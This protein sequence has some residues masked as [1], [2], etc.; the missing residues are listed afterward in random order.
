MIEGD[1][2]EN[3]TSLE[4][5]AVA[6]D[7]FL[8]YYDDDA[9]VRVD[10]SGK[11]WMDGTITDALSCP[12]TAS[13]EILKIKNGS[14]EVVAYFDTAGNLKLTGKKLIWKDG[15]PDPTAQ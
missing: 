14:G 6:G 12:L 7:T 9:I 2:K 13:S 4:L 11:M 5:D 1:L 10:S 3:A 8:L 15:D